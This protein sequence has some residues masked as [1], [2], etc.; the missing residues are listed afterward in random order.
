LIQLDWRSAR[1]GELLRDQPPRS[2]AARTGEIARKATPTIKIRVI[3]ILFLLPK[4]RAHR[5]L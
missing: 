3:L 2:V 1:K 4:E 5:A